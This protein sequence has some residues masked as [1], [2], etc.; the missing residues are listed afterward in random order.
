MS[1]DFRSP[2][3]RNVLTTAAWAAPVLAVATATPLVA[4]SPNRCG[5]M[6]W[7]GTTRAGDVR[8]GTASTSSTSSSTITVTR[9]TLAGSPQNPTAVDGNFS[10]LTTAGTGAGP[11]GALRMWQQSSAANVQARQRLTITSSRPLR[12]VKFLVYDFGRASATTS[13]SDALGTSGFA[14]ASIVRQNTTSATI[15]GAGTVASPWSRSA[16]WSAEPT[17]TVEVT[18]SSTTA[19]VQSFTLEYSNAATTPVSGSGSQ[20]W[21]SLSNMEF[22]F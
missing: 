9:A 21:I 14:A 19:S 4:A 3:R 2:S 22:C 16:N 11:V 5:T 12:Q 17:S 7:T 8:T 15:V 10:P 6:A 20:Q 1:S 13:Y 18:L